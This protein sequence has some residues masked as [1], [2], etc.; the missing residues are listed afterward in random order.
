MFRY[1]KL[2]KIEQNFIYLVSLLTLIF[3]VINNELMTYT[4]W[5]GNTNSCPQCTYLCLLA[6]QCR[7]GIVFPMTVSTNLHNL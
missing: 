5:L 7:L 2:E 6:G 1:F 4:Y 3:I